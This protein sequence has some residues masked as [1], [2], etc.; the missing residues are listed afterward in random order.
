MVVDEDP[1]ALC[2]WPDAAVPDWGPACVPFPVSVPY[3]PRPDLA[4][5]GATVHGRL[6]ARLL[7]ADA[8]APSMLRAKFDRLRRHGARCMA[9]APT[10]RDDADGVRRRVV[11]AAS[12]IA[13]IDAA[14]RGE[15]RGAARGGTAART[16][17]VDAGAYPSAPL[18]RDGDRLHAP[19]AGWSFPA[20]PGA[21]FELVV[22]RADARAVVGWIAA[23]PPAERP[24]HALGLALQEDVVWVEPSPDGAARAALLHVCWPS[25]WDPRHKAGLDFA[26][27][28][29][30]VADAAMLRAAS[31]PLSRALLTQ[32][33]FVRFVWTLAP[34]GTR[35]RHPE[36]DVAR[37]WSARPLDAWFRCE[38]Q[39]SVPIPPASTWGDGAQ[40]VP[41]D[42]GAIFL[43]RLHVAP[44]AAVASSDARR[45]A[46]ADALR[47]MS[48]ATLDYKGLA[49]PR[50]ALLAWLAA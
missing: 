5:L 13:R 12:A 14:T 36:D 49:A 25:G 45:T 1:C 42:G 26:A 20:D 27:I 11:A 3:R 4:R 9:L 44:L 37:P 18:V 29:A 21:P 33:P 2:T 8:D 41:V 40:G 31:V 16:A 22:E 24:L 32:G 50:D 39:T 19:L 15:R 35:S 43:I 23:R 34:D 28:H 30:P 47:S 7:D 10:L 46:I 38:R 17:I 6:E 48:A